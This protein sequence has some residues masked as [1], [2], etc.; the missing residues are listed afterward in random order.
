[1]KN[2]LTDSMILATIILF[3]DLAKTDERSPLG[4]FKS[5]GI[6]SLGVLN[7]SGRVLP[8]PSQWAF[9]RRAIAA[10]GGIDSVTLPGIPEFLTTACIRITCLLGPDELLPIGL[11][12]SYRE[13]YESEIVPKRPPA[14]AVQAFKADERY[15]DVLRDLLFVLQALE[16]FSAALRRKENPDPGHL[17][18]Y[19]EILQHRVL[20]LPRDNPTTEICRRTIVLFTVCTTFP[21]PSRPV[22]RTAA[23]VLSEALRNP[24][25]TKNQAS[26]FLFWATMIGALGAEA[27]NEEDAPLTVFFRGEL[28]A[29]IQELGLESWSQAK[30]HLQRYVWYDRA[31]D[32]GG[33]KL[34][35]EVFQIRETP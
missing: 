25:H 24:E 7:N 17:A 22:Q 3:W 11:C 10:R 14:S 28:S 20:D 30:A 23:R 33:R 13:I 35:A 29:R 32:E 26:S 9:F 34:W 31:C 5:T 15:K 18:I 16:K 8:Y 6:E 21:H 4:L 1:M 19:R 12:R 27:G 2:K